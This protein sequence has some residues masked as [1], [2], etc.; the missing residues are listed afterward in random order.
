METPITLSP[1][2]R[3]K[4]DALKTCL[5]KLESTAV[6]FSGGVDS[7]FLLKVAHDV[8]GDRAVAVTAASRAVP[9]RELKE[10]EEFCRKEGIRQIVFPADELQ[11]ESFL[12]NP[13]N[14]CYFCKKAIFTEIRKT[15]EEHHLSQVAEG[16]NLD[17]DGDYRPGR[18]AVME[19]GI[20][21]PLRDC[22]LAKA[23]I[24]QLSR[25]LN[26]PTWDKQSCA[27]LASRFVYGDA[28]TPEKLAMADRAEQLLLD[29]GFHQIRVRVHGTIARIEVLEEEFPLL[30]RHRETIV[31]E[32]KGIGFTYITMD[33]QGYR[34]GSMN[35][36]L[37][38]LY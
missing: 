33:L 37:K 24:R 13:P 30:L 23:E 36:T 31:K 25:Y 5:K 14:R 1:E 6:A 19:L 2:L 15:A 22:G 8:L 21:S 28:I 32:L 26:L 20:R 16:S 3:D 29:L 11:A 12:T 10:A 34:T 35:E 27:C 18:Q 7:T 38:K 4:L 17:D 9:E